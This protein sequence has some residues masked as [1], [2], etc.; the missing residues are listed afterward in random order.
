M[1]GIFIMTPP[2]Q[3]DGVYVRLGETARFDRRGCCFSLIW[4]KSGDVAQS[5][6]FMI[7]AN[8]SK[9]SEADTVPPALRQVPLGVLACLEY[10]G[11]HP[12]PFELLAELEAQKAAIGEP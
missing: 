12:A 6:T 3:I 9:G 1:T 5:L 4:V 8:I 11:G 2:I 10:A 7:F